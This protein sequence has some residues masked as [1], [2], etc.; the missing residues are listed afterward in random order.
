MKTE[1]FEIN[2]FDEDLVVEVNMIKGEV[3]DYMHPDYPDEIEIVNIELN[4]VDVTNLIINFV[5]DAENSIKTE[6]IERYEI[7]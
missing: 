3:G 2:A 5:E 4:D 7:R 1:T 6:I